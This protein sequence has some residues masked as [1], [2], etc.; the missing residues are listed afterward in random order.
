MPILGI[1][2]SVTGLVGISPRIVYITTNDTFATV[3]VVGYLNHAV[4]EGFV[5]SPG[6]LALVGTTQTGFLKDLVSNWFQIIHVAPNWTLVAD[7]NPGSVVLPTVANAIAGFTNTAGQ[8][9]VLAGT[10]LTH[11]GAINITTTFTAGTGVIATTGNIA[12][13]AGN[14]DAGS[15]GNAGLFASF[16]AA[17]NNG[18]LFLQAVNNVNNFNTTIRNSA[19]GQ[20]TSYIFPDAVNATA[21]ILVAA[22]STPFTNGHIPSASGTAGL[23]VDSG[24]LATNVQLI[25]G[26][27]AQQTANIGGA[28]AGPLNVVSASVTA[29]SVIV[30]S[31]ISSSNPCSI[32]AVAPGAGS[33]NITVSA[34]P[35]AN[36][37]ISYV[38]YIAA[39]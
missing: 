5:F 23:M 34:D 35:G 8:I 6:D 29:A 30:A 10:T 2:T 7:I 21:H 36:L 11:T 31:V 28:G 18:L 37:F 38:A 3:S 26:I 32:I 27:K 24:I 39:Q 1:T 13:S 19:I 22:T 17:A 20:A 33:F 14:V 12:A 4:Q 25:N 9:G 16:P 15:N